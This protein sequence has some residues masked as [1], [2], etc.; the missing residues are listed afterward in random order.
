[1][2]RAEANKLY[3]TFVKGMITEAGPLTYPE[4]AS[5]DEDNCV[6]YRTGNRSRRLGIDTEQYASAETILEIQA[7]F[8]NHAVKEFRW[9]S[10]AND[11]NLSFSVI[12][13]GLFIHFFDLSGDK[14]LDGERSF[15][16]NLNDFKV[17]AATNHTGCEVSFASG[18]GLLFVVGEK[19]EPFFVEY[20][21]TT[22][23]I[24]TQRIYI[25]QRDFKGVADGLANDEEPATLSDAHHYNLRN[26]GWLD[27]ANDGSGSSVTYFT[28]FGTTGT[29]DQAPSTPITAYEASTSRY[30][31]N[32]KQWWIA[33]DST[34]GAFDPAL[35]VKE[36]FGTSLAPR[37]HYVVDAFNIDRSAVSGVPNLPIE[38]TLERP[39]SVAFAN[40]RVWYVVNG[41]VYFSQLL[42]DKSRAG[43]CYQEADPT[44][45]VISDLIDTDGGVIPIPDMTKGLHL[46]PVGTG[47]LV[48]SSNGVWFISGTDK[49]FTALD[50]SVSKVS[51]IGT[52]SPNSI[53]SVNNSIYWWSDIGIQAISQK[54]GLFGT[55]D[56]V[57]DKQN[58][59]EQTIQ[60]FYNDISEDAK[61][62]V[63]VVYDPQTNVIQWLYKNDTITNN[64]FYNRILNLD[65]TLQAF[66]PWT[67]STSVEHP[68]IIGLLTTPVLVGYL[69]TADVTVRK[70]Y[71]KYLC[72]VRDNG[73]TL[74]Y[75]LNFATFNSIEFV[76][77]KTHGDVLEA[78]PLTYSSYVETGYELLED[79]MRKKQTP[80]VF[81]YFKKTEENYVVDG[82]DYT[83]DRQ[84]SCLFQVKWDWSNSNKSGKYSTKREAYR[85][86]RQPSFED[87]D[88]T[89]DT[90]YPI[91]VTKHKVRGSG[92]AI[93]FRFESEAS[94]KDFDLLGWSINVTGSTKV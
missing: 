61:K 88:T 33:K 15:K 40:G 28:Q 20:R 31:G 74:N 63:K 7:D 3:R 90:G 27:A 94:G 37:G 80:W 39:N 50:I 83:T 69:G 6:I 56:G 36:Y 81:T 72:V 24:V 62:Y 55:V 9:D 87:A 29:V 91:V 49:G 68:Y 41:N 21:P 17:A 78:G 16:V 26:Q 66:Y 53:V 11:A 82:D 42:I 47:M 60:T 46:E 85:H 1:M 25:Q 59:T 65:L 18:K 43:F 73:D 86:V 57:F 13:I 38:T 52:K 70:T 2:A 45:E 10:V 51:P 92:R 19:F 48:F 32:N 89:F 58:I 4:D 67:I 71:I 12:Q 8:N 34:T 30:P 64:Y 79:A 14:I 84:S 76:D 5:I 93:Q 44:S 23:S 77:W 75:R 35:L 54:Q 22:Q